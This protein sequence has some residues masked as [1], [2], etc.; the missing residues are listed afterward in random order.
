[1]RRNLKNGAAM[2][3]KQ[4]IIQNALTQLNHRIKSSSL[5]QDA[6]N[7]VWERVNGVD[8]QLLERLC[9]QSSRP[10]T[11]INLLYVLCFLAGLDTQTIAAIF[12]I[13]SGTVYSVRYRLRAYFPADVFLPF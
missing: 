2:D 11:V 13:E 6:K 9:S 4:L 1:L 3:N 7:S 10:L 5:N 12:T 8:I